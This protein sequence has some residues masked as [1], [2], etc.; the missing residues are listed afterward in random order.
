MTA[1]F[2]SGA[3]DSIRFRQSLVDAAAFLAFDGG[4]DALEQRILLHAAEE[5]PPL[6]P[7]DADRRDLRVAGAQRRFEERHHFARRE[8]RRAL[9]REEFGDALVA[10]DVTFAA[11]HAPVDRQR[12]Q[13][14]RAAMMRERIEEGVGRAVISLRRIAED[15][16]DR[17]EHHEAIERQVA[18]AFVQ[19]PGAAAPS[20]PSR[21]CM[22]SRVSAASGASSMTIARWKTPRSG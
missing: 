21:V 1:S 10:R 7:I 11:E 12:W 18:R 14:E 5:L 17:R 13:T 9:A 19:Q 6:R 15:A 20:A 4:E 22:R 3:A 16:R 8:L 2:S